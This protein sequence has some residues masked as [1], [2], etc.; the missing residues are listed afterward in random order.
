MKNKYWVVAFYFIL[1]I[2]AIPWYWPKDI[3]LIVM[4]LPVWV[5][6]AIV[7]S[8]ITSIF[9]AFLLIRHPWETDIKDD[10]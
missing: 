6:V 10:E 5:F 8:I 2:I 7:V 1:L 4:G 3:D 9:T